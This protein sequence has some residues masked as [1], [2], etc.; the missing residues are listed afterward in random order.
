MQ[1]N[2]MHQ[3][4]HKQRTQRCCE[5]KKKGVALLRIHFYIQII[6]HMQ[7]ILLLHSCFFPLL[8]IPH[9]HNNQG[10]NFYI[11]LRVNYNYLGSSYMR[12]NQYVFK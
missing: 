3:T 7:K 12:A 11:K 1:K 8:Q 10:N 2:N 5:K 4:K 9:T 6:I